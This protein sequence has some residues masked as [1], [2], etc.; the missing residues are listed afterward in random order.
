M[1]WSSF[2]E[3]IMHHFRRRRVAWF[4]EAFPDLPSLSVLDVGGRPFIWEL[5]K[6]EYGLAPKN[7][8]ILNTADEGRFPGYTCAEGDGRHLNYS[9]KEFDL[10]FSNSVIEH[11]GSFEDMRTF[12]NE[13]M[14]VG[15]EVYIQTP[16]RWFPVEPHIVTAL[17]HWLPRSMFHMVAFISARYLSLHR[18]P[19]QFKAI[20]EGIF[21]LSERQVAELF[22]G[23]R[24]LKERFL[25]MTKSFVVVDR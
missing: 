8:I 2:I 7:L 23:K 25:G 5:I 1:N 14:R 20:I 13:C 12:A 17:I 21:L 18:N 10:V 16:N 3:P 19:E 24:I 15:K 22:R 4:V 6:S 9:D 11:V